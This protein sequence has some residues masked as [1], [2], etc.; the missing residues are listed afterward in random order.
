M[1][2]TTIATIHC[3]GICVFPEYAQMQDLIV[4]VKL[5]KLK[6]IIFHKVNKVYHCLPLSHPSPT[7]IVYLHYNGRDHYEAMIPKTPKVH[8]T[9]APTT[10]GISSSR[11]VMPSV[12]TVSHGTYMVFIIILY[13][14]Q[15]GKKCRN[16]ENTGASFPSKK[17]LEQ[18]RLRTNTSH[19]IYH[20]PTTLQKPLQGYI[21]HSQTPP[22]CSC[23]RNY[24]QQNF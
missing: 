6:V 8:S 11:V 1:N 18:H 13:E 5:L 12:D 14:K 20:T 17:I 9:A 22:N 21:L 23:L 7:A 16:A 3:I 24:R 2:S 4:L 19:S 10:V 15:K